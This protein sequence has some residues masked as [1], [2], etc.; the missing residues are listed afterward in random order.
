MLGWIWMR[1]VSHL[2]AAVR[3]THD[4]AMLQ[5]LQCDRQASSLAGLPAVV[6][7]LLFVSGV[8]DAFAL[9]GRGHGAWM[10]YCALDKVFSHGRLPHSIKLRV[11]LCRPSIRS[12]YLRRW[13]QLPQS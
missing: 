10:L 2:F 6:L 12:G 9:G 7:V 5:V 11:R 3:A 4:T 1:P 8:R 13:A